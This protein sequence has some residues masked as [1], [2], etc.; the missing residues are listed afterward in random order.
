MSMSIYNF[1]RMLESLI[2]RIKTSKDISARNKELILKFCDDCFSEG[3]STARVVKC[4]STLKEIARMLG[5]DFDSATKDDIKAFVARIE[6]SR[7]SEWTKH[8]YK[9][10][11]KKFYRWLKGLQNGYP[12]EVSWIKTTMRNNGRK[13]PEELLTE[14]DVKRLIDAVEG[15]R[16]KALI[17]VLYES[18]CR[19]G[20]LLSLRL[21]HIVFDD[22]GAQLI[23]NGKTGMRRIRIVASAPYLTEWVNRHPLKDEPEAHLWINREC[24]PLSYTRIRHIL[25]RAKRRAGVRKKVNPH[26]FRHSRAT[27]LANHLT[28]AQMKEFFGWTQSSRMASIYVHLSGRDV[29]NAILSIYGIKPKDDKGNGLKPKKCLRCGAINPPTNKYCS[30]CGMTLDMETANE[31]IKREMEKKRAEEALNRLVEDEEFRSLLIEKLRQ[32]AQ[33]K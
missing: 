25:L 1:G 20:E 19:I 10:I 18:G 29:D 30:K 15:P 13:L 26:N 8:D 17:A 23:V 16:D 22:Y 9:A 24:K 7:Y 5:K 3:L 12:E 33:L 2:S 21:K 31:M 28:E 27:H 4:L 6:R 11:L 14:E 32:F